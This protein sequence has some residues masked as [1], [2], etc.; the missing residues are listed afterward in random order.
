MD[1][2]Q[3]NSSPLAR[4][5]GLL[6]ERV[7]QETIVYDEESGSAH[8]LRPL[9]ATVFAHCD[10]S[11]SLETLSAIASADLGEPVDVAAIE[12]A[13]AQLRAQALLLGPEPSGDEG[14]SRRLMLH[15]TAIA[16][17]AALAA[18]LVAS[19][20]APTPAFASTA[21]NAG[22]P[23]LVDSDCGAVKQ[24]GLTC[25]CKACAACGAGSFCFGHSN[26]ACVPPCFAAGA[27]PPC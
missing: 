1:L 15:K 8:C 18:P 19:I 9:A 20:V 5:A 3:T 21:C 23:C 2:G 13:L 11:N 22:A 7:G 24:Y 16:G 4:E 6:V 26:A 27:C 17:G 25:G 14:V 12:D 10:G